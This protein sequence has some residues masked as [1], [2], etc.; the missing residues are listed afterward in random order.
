VGRADETGQVQRRRELT[1]LGHMREC[2]EFHYAHMESPDQL[3]P[4]GAVKHF[5]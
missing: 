1:P 3:M 4:H 5:F 2:I